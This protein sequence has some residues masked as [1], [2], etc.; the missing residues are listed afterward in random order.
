MSTQRGSRTNKFRVR[1]RLT[2]EDRIRNRAIVFG[3]LTVILAVVFVIWGF[4]LFVRVV[5][6][7]GDLKSRSEEN[8]VGDTIPP[9]APRISYIPEATNSATMPLS[10]FTEPNVK[11]V[12]SFNQEI[13]ETSANEEGNFS[14][15]KIILTEGENSL[16]LWAEDEAENKSEATEV[17]EIIYDIQPPDLNIEF[18]QNKVAL[19]EQNIEVKG[20]TE[21]SARVLVNDH[22]VIIDEVG[23][24][25]EN[26]T[27]REGGNEIVIIAQDNA[28]NETKESISVTYLP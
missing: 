15:E 8:L 3:L 23:G 24:F 18:P 17:F 27:L 2:E 5:G 11:V 1:K 26:L 19:E 9:I 4:P 22:V 21:P 6:F 25:V 28:G 14:V 13:I 7:L 20:Q 10:G 12:V 16:S